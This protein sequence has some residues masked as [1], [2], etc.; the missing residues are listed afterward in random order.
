MAV[1]TFLK[2]N[3]STGSAEELALLDSSAGAG[4]AGRGVALDANGQLA[5][6]MM[7]TGVGPELSNLL[8]YENLTAGDFVTVFSDAGTPKARKADAT[9]GGKRAHGFVKA[10]PTAGQ[11]VDVYFDGANSSLTGLTPGSRY[12]LS[13]STPGGATATPPAA[14]GNLVQYLGTALS[15]TKIAFRPTDGVIV[16]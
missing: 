14:T 1:D 4:S 7:P 10:S 15:T 13:A 9:D 2:L 8:A 6:N 3:H 12:F 5:L 16:A 11:T